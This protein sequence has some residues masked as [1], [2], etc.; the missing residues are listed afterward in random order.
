RGLADRP[1]GRHRLSYD[2]NPYATLLPD[3]QASREVC[4]LW[5]LEAER[6]APEGDGDGALGAGRAALK[7]RR[8]G[9]AEACPVRPA[10]P[11]SSAQVGA[12][13]AERV[14][15]LPEPGAGGLLKLQALAED[16]ARHPAYRIAMRGERAAFH[17]GYLAISRGEVSLAELAAVT[18]GRRSQHLPA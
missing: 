14:L 5:R 9:G 16:E 3:V 10:G 7:A 2:R 8:S 4:G 12:G 18:E 6:L 17:A 13:G 11:G 15:G 1:R